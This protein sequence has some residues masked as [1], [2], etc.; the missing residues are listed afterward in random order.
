[1]AA[2]EK[3]R[4]LTTADLCARYGRTRLTIFRWRKLGLIPEGRALRGHLFWTLEEIEQAE[5]TTLA[6]PPRAVGQRSQTAGV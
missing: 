3:A 6:A 4:F 1:M 2:P 5:K